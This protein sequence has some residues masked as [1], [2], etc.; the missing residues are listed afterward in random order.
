MSTPAS[1]ST[2]PAASG[3]S[4]GPSLLY[5]KGGYAYYG[6]SLSVTDGVSSASHSDLSG[7]TVGGGVE[8]K[9]NPEWSLKAEYQY[10][11][12]STNQLA[13]PDGSFTYDDTFTAQTFKV[14]ANY[15]FC[16]GY[17]PLK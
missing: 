15:H 9:I 3:Y 14:G 5:A 4:W 6:G 1:T 7:W 12:F 10:F 13:A 8:Y 17:Q 16:T 11:E 2:S